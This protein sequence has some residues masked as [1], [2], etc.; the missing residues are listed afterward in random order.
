MSPS[1]V[2]GTVW[3]SLPSFALSEDARQKLQS[4]FVKPEQSD[5]Q[6]SSRSGKRSSAS[7]SARSLDLSAAQTI[8]EHGQA[9]FEDDQVGAKPELIQ[10]LDARRAGN[11]GIVLQRFSKIGWDTIVRALITLN[12]GTILRS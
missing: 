2:S 11:V 12:E 4:L 9:E 8:A 6:A 5:A 7:R 1:K 10:L 3:E